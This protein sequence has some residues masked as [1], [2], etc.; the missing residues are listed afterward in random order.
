[1]TLEHS[2]NQGIRDYEAAPCLRFASPTPPPSSRLDKPVTLID[3]D[4]VPQSYLSALQ[5]EYLP[6]RT[7]LS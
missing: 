3:A 2:N 5:K 4:S 7:T 6:K 1:M